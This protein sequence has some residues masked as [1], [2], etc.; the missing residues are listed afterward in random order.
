MRRG[1]RMENASTSLLIKS[2]DEI[3]F[4]EGM[5]YLF[6]NGSDVKNRLLVVDGVDSLLVK[7]FVYSLGFDMESD[8][9]E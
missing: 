9:G 6:D 3:I 4:A 7:M 2:I 8:I 1:D 5:K